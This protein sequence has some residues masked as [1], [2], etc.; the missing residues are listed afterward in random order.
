M[1]KREE[2]GKNQKKL[3]ETDKRQRKKEEDQSDCPPSHPPPA[4][5]GIQWS[6]FVLHSFQPQIPQ[7]CLSI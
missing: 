6:P 4:R 1:E 3:E 7:L 5:G 2:K